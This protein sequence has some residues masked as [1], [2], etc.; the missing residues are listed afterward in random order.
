MH[1]Y[2]V[3]DLPSEPL[4]V[5]VASTTGQGDPPD[6]MRFFWSFLLRKSLPADSLAD[7]LFAVFGLGDSGYAKFNFAAKKLNARLASLG[8]SEL[9]PIGLGDDQSRYG[10]DEAL[11]PWLA[12]LWEVL[13][14]RHPLPPGTLIDDTVRLLAP[15]YSITFLP[16]DDTSVGEPL[17]F[18]K[19]TGRAHGESRSLA[20]FTPHSAAHLPLALLD[21]PDDCEHERER[22]SGSRP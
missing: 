11:D 19:G 14:A 21:H 17:S 20:T 7:T 12:S 5:C 10:Y 9:V 22:Y 6:S 8:A 16:N 15:R 18:S 3:T 13:L 2:T 1:E 4:V